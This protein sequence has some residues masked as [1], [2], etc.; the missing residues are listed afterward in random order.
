MT[1]ST[2]L[3]SPGAGGSFF[4]DMA[5]G[6]VAGAAGV[7]VMDRVGWSMYQREDRAAVVRELQARRGGADVACTDGERAA[8]RHDSRAGTPGKD[9][10]HVA[11]EKLVSLTGLPLR[12]EQRNAAGIV[13]HYAL[14]F[15]P[16]A[17]HAIVRRK[18]PAVRAGGGALYGFGLF[19]LNDEILAPALGLASGPRR[20]P[21]QAHARGMVTHVVLGV[22]TERALRLSDRAR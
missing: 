14:G 11:V 15:V 9:T 21:W 22:V 6:T 8:L 18:V 2:A 19:L 17:L 16:G 10:A 12:T 20:Y 13:V 5:L 3:K 4:L 7:W 1:K